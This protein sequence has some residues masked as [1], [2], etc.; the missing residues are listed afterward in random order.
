MGALALMPKK[1]LYHAVSFEFKSRNAPKD[2][3]T[4]LW[5]PLKRLSR[6]IHI[7]KSHQLFHAGEELPYVAVQSNC[8]L[9]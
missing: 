3:P 6:H 1:W 9:D 5:L 7:C 2:A 4:M 8:E